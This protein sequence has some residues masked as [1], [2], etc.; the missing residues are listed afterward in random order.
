MAEE[1]EEKEITG[2]AGVVERNV[3]ALQ[4]RLKQEERAKTFEER[5]ADGIT[6][7][8]GSMIFVYIH[9]ALFSVWILWNIGLL[10]LR[11]FDESFVVLAMFASVEAIF[12]STFVLISQN[13]SNALAD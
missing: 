11:P 1:R 12:L 7:F 3:I 9:L 5:V 2:M 8:T 4:N 10:G 13:R 6:S